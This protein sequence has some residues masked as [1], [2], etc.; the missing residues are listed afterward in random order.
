MPIRLPI[1]YSPTVSFNFYHLN[2]KLSKNKIL[3]SKNLIKVTET[4]VGA[5]QIKAEEAK[6]R[7]S[8][9]QILLR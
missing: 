1:K 9:S 5:Q 8:F 3:D 6:E 7:K 2:Y 4:Q